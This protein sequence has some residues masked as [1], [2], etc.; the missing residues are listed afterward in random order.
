MSSI[1]HF[2]DAM[3][4]IPDKSNRKEGFM[5]AHVWWYSPSQW[6]RHH[7]RRRLVILSL[8][9][10]SKG[11]WI[12]QLSFSCVR[13]RTPVVPFTQRGHLSS[14][15]P[16]CKHTQRHAFMVILKPFKFTV[17]SKLLHAWK[18]I[19]SVSW[20]SRTLFEMHETFTWYMPTVYA[21]VQKQRPFLL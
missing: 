8:Q 17:R 1:S 13:S 3:T 21:V 2:L 16:L 20:P 19:C 7:G 5:E 15:K 9:S 11:W 14:D 12:L 10:G 6:G 18:P 4:K